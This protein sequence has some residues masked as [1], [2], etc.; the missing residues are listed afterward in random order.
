MLHYC[1]SVQ[2]YNK[3]DES[4]FE[5]MKELMDAVI[6]VAVV[7]FA[8]GFKAFQW[9]S[10]CVEVVHNNDRPMVEPLDDEGGR[11]WLQNFY[12]P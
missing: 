5:A 11:V 9:G 12:T 2:L 10:S 4:S 8:V 1:V 7:E 3:L 6:V